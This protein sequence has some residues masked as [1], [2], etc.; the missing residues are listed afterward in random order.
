MT[1]E[2]QKHNDLVIA[3]AIRIAQSKLGETP[4]PNLDLLA[5]EVAQNVL[6]YLNRDDLPFHLRFLLGNLIAE[7]HQLT[8]TVEDEDDVGNGDVKQIKEGDVTVTFADSPTRS[9]GRRDL[10]S[11]IY[12]YR[13]KLNSFRKIKW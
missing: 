13:S 10:E 5:E 6:N 2:H 7:Y 1:G 4:E 8:T 11:F 12:G 3:D 9:A